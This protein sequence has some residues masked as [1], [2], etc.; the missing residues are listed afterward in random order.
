M[1]V[2]FISIKT[3]RFLEITVN[4]ASNHITENIPIIA[5]IFKRG[6]GIPNK[7]YVIKAQITGNHVISFRGTNKGWGS[8]TVER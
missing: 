6:N 8:V 1:S 3:E 4:G 2:S 5:S 7:C